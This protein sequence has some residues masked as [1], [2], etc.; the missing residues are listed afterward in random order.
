MNYV[1]N[2][3]IVSACVHVCIIIISP[4]AIKLLACVCACVPVYTHVHESERKHVHLYS[5]LSD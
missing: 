4:E 1:R 3:M 2:C 5:G